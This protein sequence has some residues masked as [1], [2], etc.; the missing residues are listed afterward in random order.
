MDVR[1]TRISHVRVEGFLRLEMRRNL[2][3]GFTT[4]TMKLWAEGPSLTRSHCSLASY[5]L[6]TMLL[7]LPQ[8]KLSSQILISFRLP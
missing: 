4:K 7:D 8:E 6:L 3:S 2:K 1:S 5:F